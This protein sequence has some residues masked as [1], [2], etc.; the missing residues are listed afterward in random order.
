MKRI[1]TVSLTLLLALTIPGSVVIAETA[2][3]NTETEK[4]SEDFN[5]GAEKCKDICKNV[6]AATS[7]AAIKSA[8]GDGGNAN[9]T[10]KKITNKYGSFDD[11]ESCSSAVT[12]SY[13]QVA[14]Q[15]HARKQYNNGMTAEGIS[16]G[17]H[18]AAL[19]ACITGCAAP[20]YAGACIGTAIGATVVDIGLMIG[21]AANNKAGTAW[22]NTVSSVSSGLTGAAMGYVAISAAL[23]KEAFSSAI[24]DKLG[25]PCVYVGIFATTSALKAAA[26]IA[27]G[28]QKG[29][30]CKNIESYAGG[31]STSSFMPTLTTSKTNLSGIQTSG[32]TQT[33]APGESVSPADDVADILNEESSLEENSAMANAAEADSVLNKLNNRNNLLKE[34][35]ATLRGNL[36]DITKRVMN[37]ESIASAM[38]GLPGS[39]DSLKVVKDIEDSVKNGDLTASGLTGN[40][41]AASAGKSNNGSAGTGMGFNLGFN[42]PSSSLSAA[43]GQSFPKAA[44]NLK[45]DGDIWHEN[46]P[47]T[48]FQIISSKLSKTNDRIEKLEWDTTLNRALTG[49]PQK[50]KK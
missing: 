19:G 40:Y 42:N 34:G 1:I 12:A 25:G 13:T 5:K 36:G 46:Y 39:K 7:E 2:S 49:L 3:K 8:C 11:Y 22:Y 28:V 41:S 45:D 44:P 37:G 9:E 47:G 4:K 48:I 50:K 10:L 26:L 17:L 18:L 15:C 20:A 16:L 21:L 29:K 43:P 30:V 14:E 35:K 33:K 32:A 38:S 27:S 31:G 23:G 6:E 24:K